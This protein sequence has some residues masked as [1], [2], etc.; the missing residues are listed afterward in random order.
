MRSTSKWKWRRF[1]P[2]VA[3][4]FKIR[5]NIEPRKISLRPTSQ[6]SCIGF[7]GH[8]LFKCNGLRLST[9]FYHQKSGYFPKYFFEFVFNT[10]RLAFD[11]AFRRRFHGKGFAS[12]RNVVVSKWSSWRDVLG[13][14][15]EKLR[16]FKSFPYIFFAFFFLSFCCYCCLV[17]TVYFFPYILFPVGLFPFLPSSG[18]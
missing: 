8:M 5:T 17:L 11:G 10:A 4:Y 12:S 13:S 2:L 1:G 3:I 9:V 6:T 7:V 14:I 18:G 15:L 16:L